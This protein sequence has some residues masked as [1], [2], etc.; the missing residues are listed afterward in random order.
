[1][2]SL[3][4][5]PWIGS[6]Y[7]KGGIFKKRILVVGEAHVCGADCPNC[8]PGKGASDCEDLTTTGVVTQYLANHSGEWSRTFR[9]LERA[10]YGQE[11]DN[12]ESEQI[13]NSISFYNYVQRAMSASRMSPTREDF[14]N[15]EKY[16]FNVLESLRPELIIVCGQRLYDAM[17]FATWKRKDNIETE[18][19]SVRNGLYHL[20]DKTPVPTIAINHP[21]SAFSWEKWNE[22]IEKAIQATI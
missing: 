13:W 6:L 14:D 22:A 5:K 2:E 21:S 1:M 18:D 7:D 3:F 8:G 16:F 20:K 11:T 12:S 10:L 9:K 19:L 4:F 15:G 17:P